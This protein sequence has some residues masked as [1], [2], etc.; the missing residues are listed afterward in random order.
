PPSSS[1]KARK[2]RSLHRKISISSSRPS[3]AAPTAPNIGVWKTSPTSCPSPPIPRPIA[4]GSGISSRARAVTTFRHGASKNFDR[5]GRE[6]DVQLF[7]SILQPFF[8][9]LKE[10]SVLRCI[11]HIDEDSHQIVPKYLPLMLP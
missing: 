2:T 3:P 4:N 5:I 6:P 9:R 7:E 8:E 1:S 10:L 11:P